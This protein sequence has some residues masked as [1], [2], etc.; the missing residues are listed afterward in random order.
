MTVEG[1]IDVI[2]GTGFGGTDDVVDV[3]PPPPQA[4]S[5]NNEM[6]SKRQRSTCFKLVREDVRRNMNRAPSL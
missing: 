3:P 4:D 5:H 1:D 6:K 2:A